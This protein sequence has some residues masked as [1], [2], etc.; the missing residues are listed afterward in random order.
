MFA[1]E[2]PIITILNMTVQESVGEV[3]LR[4]YNETTIQVIDDDGN[5]Q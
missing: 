2:P 1:M 3:A 4:P 5:D